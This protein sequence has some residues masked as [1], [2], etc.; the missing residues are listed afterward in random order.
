MSRR[1][2]TSTPGDGRANCPSEPVAAA[3]LSAD[4]VSVFAKSLAQRG[5]LNLQILLRDNDAWPHTTQ[6]L[7]FG[8]QR[9]VSLQQDQEEIE[10]A[11]SQ[12]YRHAVGDQLALAQQHAETAECERRV[13]CCRARPI[14]DHRRIIPRHR[15]NRLHEVPPLEGMEQRME[16][17]RA[18]SG[19]AIAPADEWMPHEDH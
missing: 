14:H 2:L 16:A 3:E 17:N 6:E 19:R 10:G 9:S 1:A 5:D 15:L 8:D 11:R 4:K 18:A 12:L 13:G 7:V